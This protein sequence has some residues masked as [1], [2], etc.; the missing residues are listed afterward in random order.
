MI[1]VG[2]SLRRPPWWSLG[3]AGLSPRSVSD[4]RRGIHRIAHEDT[5]RVEG[6][7]TAFRVWHLRHSGT[8]RWHWN[9]DGHHDGAE[10]VRRLFLAV[11]GWD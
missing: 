9:R 5:A 7:F 3:A 1:W 11:G 8:S 4:R 6:L 10:L 2:V